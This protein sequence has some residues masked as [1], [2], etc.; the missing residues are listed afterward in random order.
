MGNCASG[1]GLDPNVISVVPG[2]PVEDNVSIP[3][4]ETRMIS[5]AAL[6]GLHEVTYSPR[7]RVLT[8][9]SK[10]ARDLRMVAI[11]W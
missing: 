1:K 11:Y 7:E 8:I 3:V 4:E 9:A 6:P 2:I 5:A 10:T